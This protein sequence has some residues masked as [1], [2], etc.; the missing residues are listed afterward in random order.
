MC[1]H[2]CSSRKGDVQILTE[3]AEG[4]YT[5]AGDTKEIEAEDLSELSA[6]YLKEDLSNTDN[7]DLSEKEKAWKEELLEK[8]E[9][10]KLIKENVSLTFLVVNLLK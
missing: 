4:E 8:V 10:K 2:R 9:I 6:T 7:G 5:F 1:G 3:T